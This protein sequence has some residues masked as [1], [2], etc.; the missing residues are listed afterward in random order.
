MPM[1]GDFYAGKGIGHAVLQTSAGLLSV[2]N[3]HTCA[4]YSHKYTGDRVL[5]FLVQP[6]SLIL[7]HKSLQRFMVCPPSLLACIQLLQLLATSLYSILYGIHI[8]LQ[9][10]HSAIAGLLMLASEGKVRCRSA[11]FELDMLIVTKPSIERCLQ[12]QLRSSNAGS[13]QT[14]MQPYA[15][16][17]CCSLQAWCNLL[18]NRC[19]ICNLNN[20]NCVQNCMVY[21]AH[22]T[23]VFQ[24]CSVL[25]GSSSPQGQLILSSPQG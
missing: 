8:T 25:R 24:I 2:F 5:H 1:H 22:A 21:L 3:T 17:R 13:L 10:A 20:L 6:F 11:T 16:H 14:P 19:S 4:N 9:A 7:W 12:S 18:S 15:S 23:C